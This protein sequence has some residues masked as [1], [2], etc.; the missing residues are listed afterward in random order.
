[1]CDRGT[2]GTELTH[3]HTEPPC[4]ITDKAARARRLW[5]TVAY[6]SFY[7]RLC[8]LQERCY[9]SY[10]KNACHCAGHL[11]RRSD[12]VEDEEENDEDDVD[13][14]VSERS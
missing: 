12:H 1:M 4:L 9:T 7:F 8:Y 3:S 2:K 5:L 6:V 11:K 10:Y 13:N 14:R